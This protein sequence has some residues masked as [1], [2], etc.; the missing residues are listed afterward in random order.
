M[1]MEKIVIK[2]NEILK[3]SK[4]KINNEHI[5]TMVEIV[6]NIVDIM[7]DLIIKVEFFIPL[8][9]QKVHEKQK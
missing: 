4:T 1:K 5:K 3:I 2:I 9:F 8:D 7:M 6:K